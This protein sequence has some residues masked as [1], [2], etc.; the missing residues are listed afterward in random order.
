MIEVLRAVAGSGRRAWPYVA[1]CP[2][3]NGQLFQGTWEVALGDSGCSRGGRRLWA[4][5]PEENSPGSLHRMKAWLGCEPSAAFRTLHLFYSKREGTEGDRQCLLTAAHPVT[6]ACCQGWTCSVQC[7][8]LRQ[9]HSRSQG[10]G[11]VLPSQGDDSLEP[12]SGEGEPSP[13]CFR[14]KQ[15]NSLESVPAAGCSARLTMQTPCRLTVTPIRA[16]TPAGTH[17][18]S[19]QAGGFPDHQPQS[20]HSSKKEKRLEN[21]KQNSHPTLS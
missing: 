12:H 17:G 6:Q 9:G 4:S 19:Y 16:P 14:E 18:N 3:S 11:K 20:T 10:A 5:R 2:L 21:N 7:V 13:L 1:F 8:L 15:R